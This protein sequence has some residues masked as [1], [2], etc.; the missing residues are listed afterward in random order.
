MGFPP[1]IMMLEDS[2]Q[3]PC[4]S[5]NQ[6]SYPLLNQSLQ[7]ISAIYQS[8]TNPVDEDGLNKFDHFKSNLQADWN[9]IIV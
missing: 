6:S 3:C 8:S 2:E 9:E 7:S 1:L 5:I 4:I